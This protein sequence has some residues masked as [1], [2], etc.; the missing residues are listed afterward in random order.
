MNLMKSVR[1][2]L[3][4]RKARQW[5]ETEAMMMWMA[6][7]AAEGHRKMLRTSAE[8]HHARLV[9][10]ILIDG[11]V[12]QKCIRD[13]PL[14]ADDVACLAVGV[15]QASRQ[16]DRFRGLASLKLVQ[17]M[18]EVENNTVGDSIRVDFVAGG[19]AELAVPGAVRAQQIEDYCQGRTLAETI[20]TRLGVRLGDPGQI[21]KALPAFVQVRGQE[22]TQEWL[23]CGAQMSAILANWDAGR[24]SIHL[25]FALADIGNNS[26]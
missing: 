15:L 21:D 12:V 16:E 5:A 25:G 18:A 10:A 1:N 20:V 13:A 9:K 26:R 14:T 24:T 7:A 19:L 23:L 6:M 22:W 11:E 4:A 17:A 8:G 2:W 3:A